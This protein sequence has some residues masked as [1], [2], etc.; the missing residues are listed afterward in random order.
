MYEV[1]S[2]LLVLGFLDVRS[3]PFTKMT[4]SGS[5]PC[6][7]DI[8]PGVHSHKIENFSMVAARLNLEVSHVGYHIITTAKEDNRYLSHW[9]VSA[10]QKQSLLSQTL[11]VSSA[12]VWPSHDEKYC[13]IAYITAI[14]L[15]SK[16][17]PGIHAQKWFAVACLQAIFPPCCCNHWNWLLSPLGLACGSSDGGSCTSVQN[18]PCDTPKAT[19]P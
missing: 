9:W 18:P 1:F 3:L 17:A 11:I 6:C 19:T 8:W 13:I 15:L 14:T 12:S 2:T 5:L 7:L 4:F 10:K 16:I